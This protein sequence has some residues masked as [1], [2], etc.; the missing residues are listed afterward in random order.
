MDQK[1]TSPKS[2]TDLP[3]YTTDAFTDYAI[4]FINEESQ[5]ED[6]PF[7]LYLAYTAPHWPIQAHEQDIKKI[8]REI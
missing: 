4:Q 1:V 2:T 3:Y 8:P 6:R 7:F 5:G